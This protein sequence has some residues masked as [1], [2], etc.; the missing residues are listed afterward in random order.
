M[1]GGLIPFV[2]A[3]GERNETFPNFYGHP[4]MW[5]DW[6]WGGMIFG[7]IMGILYIGL[8]VAGIVLLVRWLGGGQG[9]AA[10]PRGKTAMQILEERFA[11]GEI[12]KDE[13]EERRRMLSD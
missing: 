12:D 7:P 13:F 1:A 10:A 2:Q 6:G 3:V 5:G 11:R 4:H 8:I 9:I